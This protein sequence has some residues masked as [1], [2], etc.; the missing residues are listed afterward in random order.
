[1]ANT[2]SGAADLKTLALSTPTEVVGGDHFIPIRQAELIDILAGQPDLAPGQVDLFRRLS[3]ILS[4]T[5]HHEYQQ[6][7]DALKADYAAFDPDADTVALSPLTATRRASRLDGLFDRLG[8][9]LG[10]ANFTYLSRDAI[11]LA[12]SGSTLWGLNLTV[13]FDVF[14]RLEIYVRGQGIEAREVRSWRTRF[15]KTELDADTYQRLVV[16][17]KLRPH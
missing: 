7:L 14:D 10:R 13:D 9:L 4:A 6:E 2:V 1:M 16:L 11:E 3:Q 15:R 8:K 5:I 17:L 12:L